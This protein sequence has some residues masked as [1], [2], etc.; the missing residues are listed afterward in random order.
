MQNQNPAPI[1]YVQIET[2]RRRWQAAGHSVTRAAIDIHEVN[3][4]DPDGE[5]VW[6]IDDAKLF[7]S[8]RD[9]LAQAPD[10]QQRP[11]PPA[12]R[13]RPAVPPPT[14]GAGR[15]LADIFSQEPSAPAPAPN[16]KQLP[17]A[18]IRRDGGTQPRAALDDETISDYAEA[19]QAGA[20]FP[21][22]VVFHDG[23]AYWLADGF[24]RVSAAINA[25]LPTISAQVIP[26][27]QRDAILYSIGA[28]ATHGLRRTNADK[29]R[30]VERLLRDDEWAKWSDREIARRCSVAHPFVGKVRSELSGNVT[31]YERK[32]V[33]DGVEYTMNTA[34]I[35]QDTQ[36]E[37]IGRAPAQPAAPISGLQSPVSDPQPEMATVWQ[38]ETMV[39]GWAFFAYP[40]SE[41]RL[42]ALESIKLEKDN[43]ADWPAMMGKVHQPHRRGDLLQAINNVTDQTRSRRLAEMADGITTDYQD[44]LIAG[45]RK[46]IETSRSDADPIVLLQG[47]LA[48]ETDAQRADWES[49]TD[50]RFVPPATDDERLLAIRTLLQELQT[51]TPTPVSGLQSPV[52]DPP[53]STAALIGTLAELAGRMDTE[54]LDQLKHGVREW[55]KFSF[56]YSGVDHIALL[57]GILERRTH[58]Q[59]ADWVQLTASRFMPPA[60]HDERMVAVWAVLQELQA[61]APAPG[62][63]PAQPLRIIPG[64]FKNTPSAQNPPTPV[65]DLQSLIPDLRPAT[66]V[67]VSRLIAHIQETADIFSMDRGWLADY[68]ADVGKRQGLVVTPDQVNQELEDLRVEAQ[69]AQS[70]PIAALMSQNFEDLRAEIQ[71]RP[72]TPALVA[73]P[74]SSI[75]GLRS[76][77]SNLRSPISDLKFPHTVGPVTILCADARAAVTT[78]TTPVHLVITSP[79]YNTGGV[80]AYDGHADNLD[81]DAYDNLLEDVWRRCAEALAPGGR[82]CINVPFG[83][84]RSPWTPVT[85]AIYRQLASAGLDIEGQIVWDKGTSGNSTAWGS[86]GRPS[87]PVLRDTC[88]AIIIAAKAGESAMPRDIL[89]PAGPAQ[90][91]SPWLREEGI[92]M[93]L[94]QDHWQVAPESATRVGHPAPFPVKLAENLVRLYGWPGCHVLDPFAG[95]GTTA[96]AVVGLPDGDRCQVTL[97]DQSP[98]YCQL[99]AARLAA[100]LAQPALIRNS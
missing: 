14:N 31:R 54:R 91:V 29:R 49:L 94:T 26:G 55:L 87:N 18:Q 62:P 3:P 98:V 72:I 92:F 13:M 74:P 90:H 19:M 8:T 65:S 12:I 81:Q 66:D 25:A 22:V 32:V 73:D 20:Q 80:I 45:I 39:R 76:P 51:T 24:H 97:I 57:Q 99:A 33:R 75:S 28:N 43:A 77:V 41:R 40:D 61:A 23:A 6:R 67:E 30:A 48:R 70:Q 78:V 7:L 58:A 100:R 93:Q 35:G 38:L 2:A 89:V 27:S 50:S 88:E 11:T 46:W 85:P 84:G 1:T 95:S 5:P 96:L 42:S 86:W 36:S 4:D 52:S 83:M 44:S 47:L 21:P 64:T 10:G 59:Q 9:L 34:A 63:A 71:S 69:F 53:S 17:I 37:H 82:L 15:T 79:P 16:V 60:A 68:A 56:A